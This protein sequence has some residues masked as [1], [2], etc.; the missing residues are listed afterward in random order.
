LLRPPDQNFSSA[1]SLYCQQ[2][3]E[4]YMNDFA[5]MSPPLAIACHKT[6]LL[7]FVSS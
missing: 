2:E 4:M 1:R 3:L 7:S 6:G 5:A